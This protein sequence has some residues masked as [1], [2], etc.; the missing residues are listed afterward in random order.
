[1]SIWTSLEP[2][3]TTV[4]PGGTTTV[5]L[6]VRNTSD[7]VDEYR[8]VPVGDFAAYMTVEPD[9]IRLYPGDTG[10]VQVGFAPPRSPDATAG[11]SAYGVQVV[12]SVHPE[13][14]TV[15][16]GNLTVTPFTELR[17]ELVPPTTRGR[18]RGRP[19]LALDNLGNTRLTVSLSVAGRSSGDQLAVD[20]HP[21]TVQIEPGR[22]AF[23]KAR[24]RPR[25]ITWIGTKED[26]PFKLAAQHSGAEGLPVDGTFVQLSVVPRWVASVCGLVATLAVACVALWFAF[27]PR[28]HSLAQAEA[29]T[30]PV[31]VTALPPSAPTMAAT[32]GASDGTAAGP[33]PTMPGGGG[34]SASPGV[35][36]PG[37]GAAGGSGGGGGG[38]SSQPAAPA[39]PGP[40]P[41][42]AGDGP[43]L[44]I[45]FAQVRLRVS[46]AKVGMMDAPTVAAIARFQQLDDQQYAGVTVRS[47]GL[48]NL[49]RSTM[50]ALLMAH[51][52][53][54]VPSL[55]PGDDKPDLVWLY[56]AAIWGSNT[57]FSTSDVNLTVP[58]TKDNIEYL[59]HGPYPGQSFDGAVQGTLRWYQQDVGIPVTGQADAATFAALRAGRVVAQSAPGTV[60]ATNWPPPPK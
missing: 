28:L 1:V 22:A 41:F 30:Q 17:A 26:R 52:G 13:A 50:T 20:F 60:S 49:G 5:R 51:F 38:S 57:E 47:D 54:S 19:M 34:A 9:T 35:G 36:A 4:D 11:P 15:P 37:G 10:T 2:S 43:N 18:F 29:L 32:P 39:A 45:Q 6:R 31:A 40:L 44:F 58:L 12:P 55:Q 33:T 46:G 3:S 25:R 8:L 59:E 56:N 7:L 23:V 27:Q 16:E 14:T 53:A 48:G 21:A 24:I 42:R